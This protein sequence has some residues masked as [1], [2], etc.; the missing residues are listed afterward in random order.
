MSYVLVYQRVAFGLKRQ[1]Q[2]QRKFWLGIKYQWLS[3]R[4]CSCFCKLTNLE[5][6][7]CGCWRNV[8]LGKQSGSTGDSSVVEENLSAEGISAMLVF[9]LWIVKLP[10]FS[11]PINIFLRP[12]QSNNAVKSPQVA[13]RAG[14][15]IQ[16]TGKKS[17][18]L[19]GYLSSFVRQYQTDVCMPRLSNNVK[20]LKLNFFVLVTPIPFWG[21]LQVF[22]EFN[23]HVL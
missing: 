5:F 8:S 3:K 22:I 21:A 15:S 6:G 17:F 18:F 1:K 4:Q 10:N 2:S 9:L 12:R 20:F 16:T 19:Y 7:M 14:S 11:N 23:S 13:L